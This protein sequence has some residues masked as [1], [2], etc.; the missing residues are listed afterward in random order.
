MDR[1]EFGD[2][3]HRRVPYQ[4][5]Y[6]KVRSGV[7]WP[8][9]GLEPV[10]FDAGQSARRARIAR[11]AAV[12]AGD[13]LVLVLWRLGAGAAPAVLPHRAPRRRIAGDDYHRRILG[14]SRRGLAAVRTTV[15]PAS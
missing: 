3:R 12:S 5:C 1:G 2:H 14:R 9:L 10:D 8:A 7:A 6:P 13:V 11:G 15:G 4:S